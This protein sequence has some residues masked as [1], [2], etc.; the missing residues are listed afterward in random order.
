[1]AISL[2]HQSDNGADSPGTTHDLTHTVGSG[3][4]RLLLV[5]IGFEQDSN[6]YVTGVKWDNAGVAE[7]LT[8]LSPAQGYSSADDTASQGF[9]IVNPTPGTSKTIRVT[10]NASLSIEGVGVAAFSLEGVNTSAPIADTDG[11]ANAAASTLNVTLTGLAVGDFVAASANIEM[12]VTANTDWTGSTF[13]TNQVQNGYWQNQ[14]VTAM[15]GT[16]DSTSETVDI[17]FVTSD[18]MSMIAVAIAE[19]GITYHLAGVTKDN[20]G[21]ALGSCKCFLCKDNGDSTC[22]Y[23]DYQLSN[24]STGDYDFTS[25]GWAKIK[26]EKK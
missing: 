25:L 20:D 5:L 12:N 4:N 26:V 23:V 19:L 7:A 14:T 21:N 24:A 1:M 8:E 18:H 9:Y 15:Y 3:S 16:A 11:A 22:T 17:D 6:Q 13:T 2:T 10:F